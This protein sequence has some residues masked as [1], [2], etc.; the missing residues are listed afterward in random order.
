MSAVV[1]LPG[2]RTPEYIDILADKAKILA[3]SAKVATNAETT[4]NSVVT[5]PFSVSKNERHVR[6]TI[7]S[8]LADCRI[9]L[10]L[11]T[12]YTQTVTIAHFACPT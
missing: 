7:V 12:L 5:A 11:N 9:L 8:Q 1:L 2:P 3:A 4:T 10:I 6:R